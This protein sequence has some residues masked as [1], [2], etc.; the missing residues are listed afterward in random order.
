MDLKNLET[1]WAVMY[2]DCEPRAE[3]LKDKFAVD[4][5]RLYVLDDA[6]RYAENMEEQATIIS[7]HNEILGVLNPQEPLVLLT[8][9]WSDSPT[10]EAHSRKQAIAP[11]RVHWMTFRD[12]PE[13]TDPAFI[14]WRHIYASKINWTRGCLDNLLTAVSKDEEAGVII[15]PQSLSW[16]YHPYDGGCDVITRSPATRDMLRQT[17]PEWLESQAT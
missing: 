9:E 16:L 2:P 3:I 6:K 5:L 12:D 13:E 11:N 8:V 15:A 7:R 14:M 4:W 1:N 17:F 10:P